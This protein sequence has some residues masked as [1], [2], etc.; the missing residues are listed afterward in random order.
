M[1]PP[2]SILRWQQP[3]TITGVPPCIRVLLHVSSAVVFFHVWAMF[4]L[5]FLFCLLDTLFLEPELDVVLTAYVQGCND[6]LWQKGYLPPS[7]KKATDGLSDSCHLPL[8]T[9]HTHPVIL[10]LTAFCDVRGVFH[11]PRFLKNFFYLFY[12]QCK[13]H[14]MFSSINPQ[15]SQ[16]MK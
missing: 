7:S 1:F 6:W 3:V 10:V 8:V 16:W 13:A 14:F 5:Q 11:L 9:L 15:M 2:G 12:R 4:L